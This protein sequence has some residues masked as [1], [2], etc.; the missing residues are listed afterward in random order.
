MGQNSLSSSEMDDN[1][2]T[3][4]STVAPSCGILSPVSMETPQVFSE[5]AWTESPSQ[6]DC[7]SNINQSFSPQTDSYELS[8]AA[9]WVSP[10]SSFPGLGGMDNDMNYQPLTPR[11][12][13]WPNQAE[14]CAWT[15]DEELQTSPGSVVGVQSWDLNPSLSQSLD[16]RTPGF[17]VYQQ[18]F[19]D[20]SPFDSTQPAMDLCHGLGRSDELFDLYCNLQS[21][22]PQYFT[23]SNLGPF[24][25]SSPGHHDTE[26]VT[27][28][29]IPMGY[30]AQIVQD[31]THTKRKVPHTNILDGT[32]S[33]VMHCPPR[34][35]RQGPMS[36]RQKDC[37]RATRRRK[38]IC[39]GCKISK[40]AVR[41]CRSHMG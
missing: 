35:R 27:S 9:T 5:D 20:I 11:G 17:T 21:L 33:S 26:S 28:K 31:I 15:L 41:F 4:P 10:D 32:P 36:E 7:S 18:E 23:G 16:C 39:I 3:F 19:G 22:S 40:V 14:N 12:S 8:P 34:G 1:T 37:A 25:E 2:Y 13:F 24:G 30:R 29:D 38:S 6:Y